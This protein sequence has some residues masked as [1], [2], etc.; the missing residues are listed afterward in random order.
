MLRDSGR[1]VCVVAQALQAQTNQVNP[2][3]FKKSLLLEKRLPRL[4]FL[5]NTIKEVD[6]RLSK[7]GLG[8]GNIVDQV[9]YNPNGPR[10]KVARRLLRRARAATHT[11]VVRI[12]KAGPALHTARRTRNHRG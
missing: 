4:Q 9:G 10:K 1:G 6:P 12:N 7:L 3:T 2:L 5:V 8:S 11:R